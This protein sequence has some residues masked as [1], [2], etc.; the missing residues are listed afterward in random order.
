MPRSGRI[1][2]RRHDRR[3][4]LRKTRSRRQTRIQLHGGRIPQDPERQF[5]AVDHGRRRGDPHGQRHELVLAGGRARRNGM[6]RTPRL[7]RTRLRDGHRGLFPRGQGR[8]TLV[9]PRSG[10]RRRHPARHSARAPRHLGRT[11]G[12]IQQQIRRQRQMERRDGRDARLLRLQ[13]R[14]LRF[15]PHRTL[16]GRHARKPA[17][18]RPAQDGLRREPLPAAHLH[19]GHDRQPGLR[20]RG[21]HL[22]PP[23]AGVRAH[24]P[25]LR[26]EPRP[27]EMRPVR[28]RQTLR[29]LLPRQRTAL[30]G[31]RERRRRERHRAEALPRPARQIQGRAGLRRSVHGA[32]GHRLGGGRHRR[33][34]ARPSPTTI[35][36][37]RAR[38]SARPTRS[39]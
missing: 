37:S 11:Y 27:R 13:L 31:L 35:S 21:R 8:R 29:G 38:P 15:E 20:L 30:R 14:L 18:P 34:S 28:R 10:R 4:T 24:V 39:T 26:R 33:N 23:R 6:G 5:Q 25:E 9:F 7:R 16:P 2:H 17:Q 12:G 36:R 3:R 32:G 22:Q 1:L 19:V